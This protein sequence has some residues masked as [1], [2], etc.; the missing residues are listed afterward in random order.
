L[1]PCS[2]RLR[3]CPAGAVRRERARWCDG[4]GP[5]M[6]VN[7]AAS[8]SRCRR[9]ERKLMHSDAKG[10]LAF[11]LR[12][13]R[14]A[15]HTLPTAET[16]DARHCLGGS[17]YAPAVPRAEPCL[18]TTCRHH[19]WRCALTA[20]AGLSPSD[21]HQATAQPSPPIICR[22]AWRMGAHLGRARTP[23]AQRKSLVWKPKLCW[24]ASP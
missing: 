8:C 22:H 17:R 23:V 14:A 15:C 19:G 4:P 13:V 5:K 16:R 18:G 2:P 24:C 11:A 3:C 21:I 6:P 10:E 20:A 9:L 12:L 1:C 7:R